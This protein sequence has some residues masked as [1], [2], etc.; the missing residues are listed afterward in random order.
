[1][2]AQMSAQKGASDNHQRGRIV[3]PT[4]LGIIS[5][6]LV[7]PLAAMLIQLLMARGDQ[8]TLVE[9][10]L[11]TV[12]DIRTLQAVLDNAERLRDISIISVYDRNDELAG[13]YAIQRQGLLHSIEQLQQDQP[14]SRHNPLIELTIP[15]LL[16][17]LE[18]VRPTVGTEVNTPD[19][20]FAEHQ[21]VVESLQQ[22]QFRLADQG[23]L[24]NDGNQLSLSLLYM[25]LDESGE[26]FSLLGQARAYGSLYLRTGHVP[27]DGVITLEQIYDRL[28]SQDEVLKERVESLLK[29]HGQL[30]EVPPFNRDDWLQLGTVADYLDTNVIQAADLDL[31]WRT[32]FDAI[33]EHVVRLALTRDQLLDQLGAIYR[34]EQASLQRQRHTYLV[35]LGL[36][37]LVFVVLYL[38]ELRDTGNRLRARQEKEAAEAADHAKSQFLATMSHEIRTPINGVLGMVE[39]LSDTPLNGEQRDY[40][41]A[42]RSSGQTLLAVLNDV[43]DF[44]KIEAGQ[45]Q[46]DNVAFDVRQTLNDCM[47]LFAP[48]MKQKNLAFHCNVDNDVPALVCC[49]PSRLRQVLLNLVSNAMKFTEQGSVSVQL[50]VKTTGDRQYLYGVVR[51]TGI[52]MDDAQQTALF[53]QFSQA[54]KSIARRYGGTGLGLAICQRL[55]QLMGGEIGVSS[56]LGVGSTFWFTLALQAVEGAPISGA[57]TVAQDQRQQYYARQMRGRRVLVAEDNR[58]NQMVVQGMLKKAGIETDVVENGALAVERICRQRLQYDAVLMDWEMPEMDG[59]TACRRIRAWEADQGLPLTPIVALTAHVLSD[60]ERQAYAAG[61]QGFLKKPI[62]QDALYQALLRALQKS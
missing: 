12:Q 14:L 11:R 35:A 26:L 42:L 9:R 22:L 39:L 62:D 51:D 25:A 50:S 48:Q 7:V 43:L 44:S 54:D 61:M 27:S 4:R 30:R 49:D 2:S 37:A 16:H 5:L 15:R 46:I 53:K 29:E 56:K 18:R 57:E 47:A 34:T 3:L 1:M 8:L 10:K 21:P 32:Y 13:E 58:V 55:C 28:I 33:S 38:M 31:P 23:G 20:A 17:R 6:L 59:L 60:N 24:F 52:G 36:L 41:A 45:L 19:M 40:L